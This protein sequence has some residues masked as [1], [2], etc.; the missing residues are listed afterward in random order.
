MKVSLPAVVHSKK[1]F[2]FKWCCLNE[3]AE[4]FR[5]CLFGSL[6][7]PQSGSKRS[8]ASLHLALAALSDRPAETPWS[9]QRYLDSKSHSDYGNNTIWTAL[10]QWINSRR[11][12][13]TDCRTLSHWSWIGFSVEGLTL[14][15]FNKLGDIIKDHPDQRSQCNTNGAS[16]NWGCHLSYLSFG[17]KEV[18]GANR[19]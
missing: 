5:S 11:N 17:S 13:T 8:L 19:C 12:C 16:D 2:F 1:F 15:F 7:D 4:L 18:T 9:C 10:V 6:T 3:H 14:S